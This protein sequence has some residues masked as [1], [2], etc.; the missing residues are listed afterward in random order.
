MK[1]LFFILFLTIISQWCLGQ[2]TQ[3]SIQEI[4]INYQHIEDSLSIAKKII[5][6]LEI[7]GLIVSIVVAPSDFLSIVFTFSLWQLIVLANGIGIYH[8]SKKSTNE[9]Y[10]A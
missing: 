6:S 4:R 10:P 8:I 5:L 3:S 7:I 9:N 1:K 2:S